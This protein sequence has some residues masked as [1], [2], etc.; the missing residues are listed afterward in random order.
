MYYDEYK[1][2]GA[3]KSWLRNDDTLARVLVIFNRFASNY[4]L[5]PVYDEYAS[6]PSYSVAQVVERE[7]RVSAYL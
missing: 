3:A 6:L 2:V 7:E 1:A 4:T 5:E